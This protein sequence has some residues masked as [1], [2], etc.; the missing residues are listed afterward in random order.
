MPP[1]PISGVQGP[2]VD[3]AL[4]DQARRTGNEAVTP[5]RELKQTM[6][7]E[8]FMS[9]LVTQ[10]SNQNPSSPMDTNDMIT[11]TTQL[12]SM[13]Q[14]TAM[15]TAQKELLGMGQR[16]AATALIGQVV[17]TDGAEPVTGTVTAVSFGP[18]GPTV[19]I[20]GTPYPYSAIAAVASPRSEDAAASTD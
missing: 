7:S 1:T 12:A 9:L 5:G 3:P 2:A 18:S 4:I 10:L 13:E 19:A 11:Q 20:D 17:T 6:D 16:S 15:A 8:V 14:L